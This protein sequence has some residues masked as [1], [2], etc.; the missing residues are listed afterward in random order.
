MRAEKKPL[1][2]TRRGGKGVGWEYCSNGSGEKKRGPVK[3]TKACNSQGKGGDHL[4]PPVGSTRKTTGSARQ[5]GEAA[6]S[7]RSPE[8]KIVKN[9][10]RDANQ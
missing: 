7:K 2:S 6:G 8:I 9:P 4:N 3:K 1:I 5:E 10:R